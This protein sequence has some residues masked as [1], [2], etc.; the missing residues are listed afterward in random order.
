M[1]HE[2][3]PRPLDDLEEPA[4]LEGGANEPIPFADRGEFARVEDEGRLSP[5]SGDGGLLGPHRS[6]ARRF[7]ALV[8]ITVATF[9]AAGHTLRQPVFM[10]A[11]DISRWCTVWS[12]LERGRYV[13]DECPWQVDTQDKIFWPAPDP[14]A[15]APAGEQERHYYSSKPALISTVIAG[16]L[17]PARRISG[18]PLDRV[19]LQERVE[20]N[21]QKPDPEHPGQLIGVLEKPKE[22]VK[23]PVTPYYFDPILILINVIP[24]GVFLAFF[25]RALDRYAANEWS[26]YFC[27]VAAA[28]GTFLL[29]YTQTLNN[30]TIGAFAAFFAVYHFLRIWDERSV[31]AWR[32]AGAGFFAGLAAST[33]LPALSLPALMGLMLVIRYPA[34]TFLC[35]VPA[36]LLP[37]AAFVGAQY[38][39]FHS[40]YLPYEGF[41]KDT[42]KYPGSFWETPLELDYFNEHPEP[43]R[44]YLFHMTFGHHGIFSLTPIYLFSAWGAMRLLGGRR[45]L[46]LCIVLTLVTIVGLGGY[47]LSNPE[48]WSPGGPLFQYAWLLLSIPILFALLV[49]LSAV[50]WLRGMDRPMEA[51]AWM[52]T[53]LTIVVVAFYAYTPKAR[54]Y[55]GSAQGLRWVMWLIP[56]WLLLLPK[57]IE[58]G[59]ARG[60]LRTLAI[61]ALAISALS[62]GYAMR[63]PWSHPWILDAMEQL[64]VYPLKK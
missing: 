42:Y 55:G 17:Y 7:A 62:I 12:L 48:A 56:L 64:G 53:V 60:R 32:F 45:L 43:Y 9:F 57:G 38:A 25:A 26:W 14:N 47:Y 28:F 4:P 39:E 61:V 37:L 30:H 20:R 15:E 21:V 40:F 44:V 31:S 5:G 59:Q 18:V 41:G 46:T 33:E 50:P 52:T 63:N 13:I 19:V 51:L 2:K 27:L 24:F 29:P 10:T 16:L 54:N 6:D 49:L 58:D 36:V 22:P 8:F 23:W 1:N 11:N 35:F 34:R 3:T